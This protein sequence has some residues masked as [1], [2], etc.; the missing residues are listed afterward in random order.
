MVFEVVLQVGA[1]L[2]FTQVVV[3]GEVPASQHV[4]FHVHLFA[5]GGFRAARLRKEGFPVGFQVVGHVDDFLRAAVFVLQVLVAA[6]LGSHQDAELQFEG[7]FFLVAQAQHER[8]AV[9]EHVFHEGLSGTYEVFLPPVLGEGAVGQVALEGEPAAGARHL[10]VVFYLHP[11]LGNGLGV[12]TFY[13]HAAAEGRVLGEGEAFTLAAADAQGELLP[14]EIGVY[15]MD[16]H[17]LCVVDGGGEVQSGF[18]A[19]VA[20]ELFLV[21]D[22]GQQ[23]AGVGL[24]ARQSVAVAREPEGGV[25]AAAGSGAQFHAVDK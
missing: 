8:L 16:G 13:Q 4:A 20:G 7:E 11:Y 6:E 15:L 9:V 5:F 3:E 2:P 24:Y 18:N 21:G 25:G 12:G 14:G 22:A 17:V 1:E 23:V 19:P 10:E